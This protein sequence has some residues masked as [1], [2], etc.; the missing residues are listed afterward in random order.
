MRTPEVIL[1]L[2]VLLAAGALLLRS[3]S[4]EGH[5]ERWSAALAVAL[6]AQLILSGLYWQ[7]VSACLAAVL[8]LLI[9]LLGYRTVRLRRVSAQ[10]AIVLIVISAAAMTL[11]PLFSLPAPTGT[12]AVGT[13]IIHLVDPVRIDPAFPSGRR[14]LMIQIWYPAD[15][16]S[17]SELAPYRRRSETTLLSSYD[18]ILK[19]HSLHE[20][21]LA[22][23][24]EPYPL[25]LFNPAWAGHRTQNTFQAE[26]L[27]SHGF[28]VAA[29]DHTHNSLPIAFPGGLVLGLNDPEAARDDQGKTLEERIAFYNREL[30]QQTQDDILVLDWFGKNNIDPGSS[31]F[32]AVDSNRIGVLGH[33]F[34]GAVS[35]QTAFQDS[36]VRAALNMDGWNFGDLANGPLMKPVMFMYEAS[37][38]TMQLLSASARPIGSSD[39][40]DKWDTE[41]VRRT[42]AEAGGYAVF[43]NGTAHMNFSDRVL[44]SPDRKLAEAGTIRPELGHRI[45]NAYTLA[46]FLETLYGI[47]QPLL[48]DPN[49]PYRE[50]AMR[51]WQPAQPR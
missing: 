19:T 50:V 51:R 49:S 29:I 13:R 47:R 38:P 25:L 26:E 15:P 42:L 28:I 9:F 6:S 8:L 22:G 4:A 24:G 11:L 31:W 17:G 23:T 5:R 39:P 41:N 32:R 34:G 45:I 36:R 37:A 20:A 43:I 40:L 14:E 30:A 46:F 18:A 10:A 35:V 21:R 16:R 12:F 27:A 44:Y 2:T 48:H 7:V 1:V 33:S 3:Y